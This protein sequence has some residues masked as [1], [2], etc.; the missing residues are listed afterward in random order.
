MKE[1]KGTEMIKNVPLTG[2]FVIRI[3]WE[4]FRKED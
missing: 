3:L 1:R 2:I 4:E